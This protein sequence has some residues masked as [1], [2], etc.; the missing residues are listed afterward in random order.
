MMLTKARM[1][2]AVMSA[3]V[4]L[5]LIALWARSYKTC[6]LLSRTDDNGWITAIGSDA[7]SPYFIHMYLA[8]A[9]AGY[10][11]PRDTNWQYLP[12]NASGGSPKYGWAWNAQKKKVQAPYYLVLGFTAPLALV[13][14]WPWL[15]QFNLRSLIVVMTLIAVYVA[16]LSVIV[17]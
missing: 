16:A 1:A 7:G 12:A 9:N 15:R 14:G 8:N 11:L 13:S 6:D 4:C 2:F 10:E 17:K 5:L 3:C